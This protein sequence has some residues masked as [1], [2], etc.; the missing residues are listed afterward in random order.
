MFV[1]PL[2]AFAVLG[3]LGHQADGAEVVNPPKFNEE[4]LG[5][6]IVPDSALVGTYFR[7]RFKS[8]LELNSDHT[9]NLIE[10][11]CFGESEGPRGIWSVAGDRLFLLPVPDLE[12][13]D[14]FGLSRVL[15]PIVLNG[16]V[17]LPDENVTPGFLGRYQLAVRQQEFNLSAELD[18]VKVEK[19]AKLAKVDLTEQIPDRYRAFLDHD[20]E[21]RVKELRQDGVVLVD[22]GAKD[23]LFAGLHLMTKEN[24]PVELVVTSMNAHSCL[25]RAVTTEEGEGSVQIGDAF[26]TGTW[27]ERPVQTSCMTYPLKW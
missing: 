11:C 18:Y 4:V 20:V 2:I 1:A 13:D 25:A 21:C 19:Y 9:F 12:F 26:H 5:S 24:S 16:H 15:V 10:M 6:Q 8:R 7:D 23:G 22:R 14:P 27:F 17:Y 3:G